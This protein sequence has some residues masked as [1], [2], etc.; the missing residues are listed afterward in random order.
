MSDNSKLEINS[1]SSSKKMHIKK[2]VGKYN[3]S[4]LSSMVWPVDFCI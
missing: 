2:Q 3:V 1:T 4:L